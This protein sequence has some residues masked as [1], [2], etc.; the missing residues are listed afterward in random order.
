[1]NLNA[2][3]SDIERKP[4]SLEHLGN[5]LQ[6]ATSPD[7]LLRG[8]NEVMIFGM[9]SSRYAAEFSARRLR[10]SGIR[11]WSDYS[12]A[13]LEY[14]SAADTLVVLVS[15]SGAT[16]ETLL[17]AEF[18][19]RRCRTIALTNQDDSP[20]GELVDHTLP[21]LAGE[22]TSGAVTRSMVHTILVLEHL[23]E[24]LSGSAPRSPRA[25]SVAAE[26]VSS[27]LDERTNWLPGAAATLD[28]ADGVYFLAPASRGCSAQQSAL[29]IREVPR[30]PSSACE[31]S[32]W[33][34]VDVYLTKTLDYRAVI[35]GRS[36][37]N[38]AALS[39]LDA[40]G[41]KVFGV[42]MTAPEVHA[43]LRYAGDD[44]LLVSA[45][46]DTVVAE[47]VAHHWGSGAPH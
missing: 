20:L 22:E 30:R 18:H 15:A 31:V 8:V 16:P 17:A 3:L 44:D 12:S 21:L 24:Q 40:R 2:L 34:H 47:L 10:S 38:S 14:A 46:V 37:G 32:D 43:S 4:E 41:A 19:G 29:L 1:M 39:W 33:S 23:A 11:A 35:F 7:T 42:G 25:A 36:D 27:L 28:S 26:A 6:S 13:A 45:L 5:S 9:G